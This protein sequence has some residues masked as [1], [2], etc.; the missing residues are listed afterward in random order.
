MNRALKLLIILIIGIGLFFLVNVFITYKK[1]SPF[2]SDLFT[3]ADKLENQQ[4]LTDSVITLHD[5]RYKD[6]VKIVELKD[7]VT[8][9]FLSPDRKLFS[10]EDFIKS[11]S[12]ELGDVYF[13]INDTLSDY[14]ELMDDIDLFYSDTLSLPFKY[15]KMVYPYSIKIDNKTIIEAFIG[16]NN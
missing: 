2:M 5:L 1:I 8:L 15:K 11:G 4:E 3:Q 16:D 9:K 14:S 13:I 7:Q 12:G 6:R 10:N